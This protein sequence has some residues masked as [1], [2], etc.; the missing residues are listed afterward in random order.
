M[1]IKGAREHDGGG[2]GKNMKFRGDM[3]GRTWVELKDGN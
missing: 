2:G 3:L 1:H